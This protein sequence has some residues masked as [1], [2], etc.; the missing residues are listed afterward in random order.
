[1]PRARRNRSRQSAAQAVAL[2]DACGAGVLVNATTAAK[3]ASYEWSRS[4]PQQRYDILMAVSNEIMSRKEERHTLIQQF[5]FTQSA[6]IFVTRL[7][8]HR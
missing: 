3:A 4:G 5:L 7:N 6:A 2:S 1:M 8:Q